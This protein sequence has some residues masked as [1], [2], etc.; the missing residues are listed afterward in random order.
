MHYLG[1][2]SPKLWSGSHLSLRLGS[3]LCCRHQP[4]DTMTIT[5]VTAF[6]I[7]QPTASTV[8]HT[9]EIMS[10][11]CLCLHK[12]LNQVFSA[13]ATAYYEG[14]SLRRFSPGILNTKYVKGSSAEISFS[15]HDPQFH[16]PSHSQERLEA[17]KWACTL[18]S[19]SYIC[20]FSLPSPS[21]G[22]TLPPNGNFAYMFSMSA[23]RLACRV[24]LMGFRKPFYLRIE[25]A[26]LNWA[27]A[28]ILRDS[29][30][31]YKC[32]WFDEWGVTKQLAKYISNTF[33][34]INLIIL[35]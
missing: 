5:S 11:A 7:V 13:A 2:R 22:L 17:W 25:F 30:W 27:M 12:P 4:W 23:M 16:Y 24:K 8:S 6:A 10:Q 18:Q 32:Y 28:S 14:F 3:L 21:E 33:K 34:N 1:Y 35:F 29:V 9:S 31:S 15:T 19:H 20:P 26:S